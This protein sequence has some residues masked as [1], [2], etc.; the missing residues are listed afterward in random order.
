MKILD[1]KKSLEELGIELSLDQIRKLELQGIIYTSRKK[2]GHRI[3]TD[4]QYAK[5]M[6]NLL[7]YYFNTSIK[8][9]KADKPEVIEKRIRD[10]KR[11][12]KILA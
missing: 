12:L 5:S 10:I 7:L 3:L 11:A 6:R 4:D 2:S 8:D 9:I 1:L